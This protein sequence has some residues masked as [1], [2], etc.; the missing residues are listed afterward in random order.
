[1]AETLQPAQRGPPGAAHLQRTLWLLWA[2]TRPEPTVTSV[3]S[4]TPQWTALC[5]VPARLK[6]NFP[7]AQDTAAPNRLCSHLTRK[8]YR[9]FYT[10]ITD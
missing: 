5:N 9:F 4:H 3:A 10:H 8:M 1:M 2:T 7:P 6:W